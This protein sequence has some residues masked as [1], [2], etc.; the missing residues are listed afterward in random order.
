MESVILQEPAIRYASLQESRFRFVIDGITIH[1]LREG[2]N[3]H[4]A[5][6][7]LKER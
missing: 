1:L 4:P 6:E 5:W 2:A 3:P 7:Q